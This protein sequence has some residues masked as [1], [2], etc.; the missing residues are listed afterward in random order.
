ME[1]MKA[2]TVFG[3]HPPRERK[4]VAKSI[5][6]KADH[7]DGGHG[8][9]VDPDG[10][11]IERVQH[12]LQGNCGEQEAE[13]AHQQDPRHNFSHDG[14]EGSSRPR[15]A[16][17]LDLASNETSMRETYP[18]HGVVDSFAMRSWLSGCAT[19]PVI[20]TQSCFYGCWV[21]RRS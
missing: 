1:V 11:P 18:F 16:H 21:R 17:D 4:Q 5:R 14:R 8:R 15:R 10:D 7:D 13:D 2:G 12:C 20:L 19:N 9:Y 6:Q 3:H